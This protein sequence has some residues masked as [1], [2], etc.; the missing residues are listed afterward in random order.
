MDELFWQFL[1]YSVL[2]FCLEVVFAWI[3]H[4]SKPDRKCHLILPVCPVYGFGA[5]GILLLPIS[6]KGSPFLLC[7]AGGL[8]AT[9]AEWGMS[10][11]YEKAAGAAFWNYDALP[12]NLGGRVCLLFSLIWGAL[13]LLLVYWVQPWLAAWAGAIPPGVTIPAAIFYLGDTALSLVV[14]RRQGTEGLRWYRR[15]TP[16]EARSKYPG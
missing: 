9:L 2:G 12:L 8:M 11:F 13:A 14:L 10:Y 16:S 3:T 1:I 4:S 5:L 7:L 15:L 6:V